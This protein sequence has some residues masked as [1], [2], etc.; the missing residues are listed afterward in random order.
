MLAYFGSYKCEQIGNHQATKHG[1]Y[2]LQGI[3]ILNFLQDLMFKDGAT[4]VIW[5]RGSFLWNCFCHNLKTNKVKYIN[6]TQF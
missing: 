3:K 6:V 1:D 2:Q 5:Y 4:L